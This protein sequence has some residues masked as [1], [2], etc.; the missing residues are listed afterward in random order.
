MGKRRSDVL[1]RD[2]NR[3]IGRAMHDYAMLADG[4]TVLVAVSG[5]VDSLV[6]A[7]LLQEWRRK[8]PIRYQLLA[9]HIDNGFAG[10]T[11]PAVARQLEHLRIPLLIEKTEFGP[12]AFAAEDGRSICFHCTRQ[13]RKRLFEIASE[14]QANKIAFGHHR[15]DLLE[16]FLLN[17]FYSGNLST[18]VP[19]LKIFDDRVS[20]IRP[21]A[22]LEK[23]EIRE[24]AATLGIQPVKNSCPQD[25][26]SR[27][28]EVRALLQSLHEKDPAIKANIFHAMGNVRDG[29]L[30]SPTMGCGV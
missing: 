30:L 13:R 2:V 9:V 3:R 28:Q 11:G 10:E 23:G 26:N 6:L 22:Y 27:R 7:W 14:Q 21:M 19:C 5:G 15:D 25:S 29:Y 18:M 24:I 16:T 17:L 12:Q 8:A 1:T 4:D 20:L